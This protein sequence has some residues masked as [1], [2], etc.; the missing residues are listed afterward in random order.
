M[1]LLDHCLSVEVV[2]F[3]NS[4]NINLCKSVEEN[5]DILDLQILKLF[6][7][8]TEM[9]WYILHNMY[10]DYIGRF[11]V[12]IMRKFNLIIFLK[13][14]VPYINSGASPGCVGQ[15]L[16]LIHH[17]FFSPKETQCHLQTQ[18]LVLK[19]NKLLFHSKKL[20]KD[21]VF[22]AVLKIIW[23]LKSKLFS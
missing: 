17:D 16:N 8:P 10:I 9:I 2:K 19:R 4:L 21:A 3:L 6:A 13:R 22:E 20:Q 7:V 11:R 23:N 5:K 14:Y 1:H 18:F 15:P 12:Y